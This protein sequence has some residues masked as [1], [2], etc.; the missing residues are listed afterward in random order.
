MASK[1]AQIPNPHYEALL[2]MRERNPSAWRVLSPQTKQAVMYY[3][4]A[5]RQAEEGSTV[6]KVMLRSE[7]GDL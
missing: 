6:T 3:E 5:K 2:R 4:I 1:E 7:A